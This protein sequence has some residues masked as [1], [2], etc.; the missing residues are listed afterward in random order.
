MMG[1]MGGIFY[2]NC[3]CVTP[4]ISFYRGGI[5][6]EKKIS[7]VLLTSF[8]SKTEKANTLEITHKCINDVY[9]VNGLEYSIIKPNSMRVI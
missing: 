3:L 9:M 2:S 6:R 7:H 4:S 1:F 5:K 8:T